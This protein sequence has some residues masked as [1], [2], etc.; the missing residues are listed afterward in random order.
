M[1][2]DQIAKAD[3][4]DARRQMMARRRRSLVLL[5]AGTVIGLIW[6]LAAGGA[7]AWTVGLLFL[8]ALAGYLFFLRN[9]AL[10]DQA[11]RAQRLQRAGVPRPH[12]YNATE[13]FPHRADTGDAV[14]IDDEDVELRGIAD[15]IDLTGT[16]DVW[17]DDCFVKN[18]PGAL[19]S[20]SVSR[21]VEGDR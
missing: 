11:R 8:A 7:V 13:Q 3:M 21:F 2:P 12:G 17:S 18:P 20:L 19:L 4:S 10:H 9:Q 14:G 6:G 15:T 5:T 16:A 1:Y